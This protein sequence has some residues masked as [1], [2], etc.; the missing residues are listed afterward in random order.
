M[1]W[2]DIFMR[3]PSTRLAA[4]ATALATSVAFLGAC[5]TPNRIEEVLPSRFVEPPA[6]SA[7]AERAFGAGAAEA[8]T[9]VTEWSMAQWLRDP[10]LDPT[11]KNS[12]NV[13]IL[14]QGIVDHMIPGTAQRWREASEAAIGGDESSRHVVQL[15]RF[16]D[17]SES[18]LQTP[19]G[20]PIESQAI[21]GGRV[22]VAPAW[23]DGTVPMTITF[24]QT[25]RI[26][27][28]NVRD[29]Y[30]ATVAKQ[31]SFT[32]VPSD[33]VVLGAPT[34]KPSNPPL[35]PTPQSTTSA[36]A[37]PGMSGPP[38]IGTLQNGV[39]ERNPD[40]Q[41]LVATFDGDLEVEFDKA[42]TEPPTDD[43]TTAGIESTEGVTPTETATETSAG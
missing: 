39:G 33:L 10:L 13:E 36:T 43:G 18:T 30:P 38:T 4:Q 16:H 6:I 5:A 8:Y 2:G 1:I 23:S 35:V 3:R 15:L 34:D 25:A 9:E 12:V 40:A 28:L 20:S 37:A 21:S 32:V 19:G 26:Q 14:S 42:A 29:P 11:A 27:L 31:V 24:E 7:A 22:D 41:W 17:W